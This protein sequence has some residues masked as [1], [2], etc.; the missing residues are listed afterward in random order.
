M[1]AGLRHR[2]AARL[3][4]WSGDHAVGDRLLQR[5][6]LVCVAVPQMPHRGEARAKHPRRIA[7]RTNEANGRI[8]LDVLAERIAALQSREVDMAVDQARRQITPAEGQALDAVSGSIK[9]VSG[10]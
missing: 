9:T 3:H 7:H 2:P 8:L 6:R 4:T 5:L 1:T 10:G